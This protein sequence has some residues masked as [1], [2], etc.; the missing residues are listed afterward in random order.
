MQPT[1]TQSQVRNS[2]LGALNNAIADNQ[3]VKLPDFDPSVSVASPVSLVT[4]GIEPNPYGGTVGDFRYQFEG[5]EDLLHLFV[6]RVD[7]GSLTVA[8]G[9]EVLR[10]LFPTIPVAQVW[11]KPGELSQHFYMGHE[12]VLEAINQSV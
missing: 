8:E 4:A 1:A 11:L 9:Q 5:E 3:T 6:T 7:G 2:I 12:V 10:W